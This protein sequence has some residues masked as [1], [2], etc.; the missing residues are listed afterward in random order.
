[1]AVISVVLRPDRTSLLL[2]SLG[3][4]AANLAVE[5]TG[6]SPVGAILSLAP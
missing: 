6:E 5:L 1:M 3:T 2:V 4:G